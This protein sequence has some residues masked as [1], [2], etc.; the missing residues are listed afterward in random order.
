MI[1]EKKNLCGEFTFAGQQTLL[2]Q[3]T[4]QFLLFF[5]LNR[6]FYKIYPLIDPLALGYLISKYFFLR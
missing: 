5:V 4:D 3:V 2:T 1:N 6:V